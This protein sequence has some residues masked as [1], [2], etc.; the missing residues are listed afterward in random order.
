MEAIKNTTHFPGVSYKDIRKSGGI[1]HSSYD[2]CQYWVPKT[3]GYYQLRNTFCRV[4]DPYNTYMFVSDANA[5][6][7]VYDVPID[8]EPK[9]G[10]DNWWDNEENVKK[11]SNSLFFEGDQD[12]FED[13][14]DVKLPERVG[15][16][17]YEARYGNAYT[18]EWTTDKNFPKYKHLLKSNQ[19]YHYWDS[20]AVKEVQNANLQ[21]LP[22]DSVGDVGD[23]NGVFQGLHNPY[24]NTSIVLATRSNYDDF[25]KAL[26]KDNAA[27][28]NK[29]NSSKAVG[30]YPI[31]TTSSDEVE[32]GYLFVMGMP[33]CHTGAPGNTEK[34]YYIENTWRYAYYENGEK[35]QTSSKKK[36]LNFMVRTILANVFDETIVPSAEEPPTSDVPAR[37]VECVW[38][39]ASKGE[40]PTYG[41]KGE[42]PPE[43]K[44]ESDPIVDIP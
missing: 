39:Y 43:G 17:F 33:C 21:T 38:D 30:D 41:S 16:A 36:F 34:K 1:V 35:L 9:I 37:W 26:G 24:T 6:T 19:G 18:G 15:K 11:V 13:I 3:I 23:V 25:A 32:K 44:T 40:L 31:T 14:L 4:T 2:H 12:V 22:E 8:P 42:T 7:P 10:V 28:W 20:S 5:P 27:Y 29:T